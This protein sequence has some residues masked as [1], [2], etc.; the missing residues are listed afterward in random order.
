MAGKEEEIKRLKDK[1]SELKI[2]NDFLIAE[3]HDLLEKWRGCQSQ[4]NEIDREKGFWKAETCAYVNAMSIFSR[5]IDVL[6]ETGD[7]DHFVDIYMKYCKDTAERCEE[8]MKE[9]GY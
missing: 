3:N 5:E 4:L 1:I 7:I 2:E 6:I 8:W 9:E